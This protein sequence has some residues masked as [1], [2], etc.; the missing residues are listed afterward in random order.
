ME[1]MQSAKKPRPRLSL[2]KEWHG[3]HY[4]L[5]GEAEP[6][7][8]L[9]SQAV[10]GGK[11]L[12]DDDE[13][14]S[15][16]GPARFFSAREVADLHEALSRPEVE[17][18][19]RAR[20]DAGRIEQAGDLSGLAKR[21]RRYADGCS[22]AAAIV[23]C[24]CCSEQQGYD[25]LPC[26]ACIK[27]EENTRPQRW[28]FSGRTVSEYCFDWTWWL[29]EKSANRKAPVARLCFFRSLDFYTRWSNPSACISSIW[30]FN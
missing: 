25:Y 26:I 4:L 5:C 24:Q 28:T 7:T 6:G 13:G 19:A 9:L 22:A 21:R 12:G 8:S 18:E 29:Y 27:R 14:F 30:R 23:L 17:P 3:V 20:F 16:Y 10:L 15:G 2:D 1:M 11:P